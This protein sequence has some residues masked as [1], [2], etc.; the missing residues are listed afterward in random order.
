MRQISLAATGRRL[1]R[2]TASSR[3]ALNR[4]VKVG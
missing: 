3:K 4:F 2:W 1:D